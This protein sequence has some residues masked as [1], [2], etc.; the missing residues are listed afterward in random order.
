MVMSV[1]ISFF[2]CAVAGGLRGA[3]AEPMSGVENWSPWQSL[4][5]DGSL[6]SQCEGLGTAQ[7]TSLADCQQRCL[8]KPGCTTISW[9]SVQVCVLSA[10]EEC[11]LMN[12]PGCM[13]QAALVGTSWQ[14]STI[15]KDPSGCR[16]WVQVQQEQDGNCSYCTHLGSISAATNLEQR[17]QF[18][19]SQHPECD[20]F[21]MIKGWGTC[22]LK[23]CNGCNSQGDAGCKL[24][25][26]GAGC[27]VFT[28]VPR[29][30]TQIAT[31]AEGLVSTC[32]SVGSASGPW[33]VCASKCLGAD[34]CNAVSSDGQQCSLKNCS[35]SCPSQWG[36]CKLTESSTGH[37]I[38][39]LNG[40]GAKRQ[41]QLPFVYPELLLP[42]HGDLTNRPDGQPWEGIPA[43]QPPIF[44]YRPPFTPNIPGFDLHG[45][46][47]MRGRWCDNTG[48]F[49]T[50]SMSV[51][52]DGMWNTLDFSDLPGFA[53]NDDGFGNRGDGRGRSMNVVFDEK[54][55]LYTVLHGAVRISGVG[56]SSVLLRGQKVDDTWKFDFAALKKGPSAFEL[57]QS[58]D[59]LPGP[60]AVL[61]WD[62]R[63]ACRS[64][65]MGCPCTWDHTKT[66]CTTPSR[67][68]PAYPNCK[69]PK[70]SSLGA[71]ELW[72]FIETG[73]GLQAMAP[74]LLSDIAL[75]M[76][77]HSG[78]SS[79]LVTH[80]DITYA[81]YYEAASELEP[82]SPTLLATV[83]RMNPQTLPSSVEF[84]GHG[85]ST[86]HVDDPH[87]VPSLLWCGVRM[88]HTFTGTHNQ[89]VHHAV[90]EVDS[91]GQLTK[92]AQYELRGMVTYL[93]LACDSDGVI[94]AVYRDYSVR[95]ED[96]YLIGG[97]EHHKLM[98]NYWTGASGWRQSGRVLVVP[99]TKIYGVFYHKLSI[100]R[101]ANLYLL[102][103]V[104]ST[105][106]PFPNKHFAG[107]IENNSVVWT[108]PASS[109]GRQWFLFEG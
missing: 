33:P 83:P 13:L 102:H 42:S 4:A 70:G 81:V 36:D 67:C 78:G 101:E 2:V 96:A 76:G 22:Y 46:T 104:S 100:D 10:C 30:F 88:L 103:T 48:C 57:Q 98:Y 1:A 106:G 51:K 89:P 7:A 68:P 43:G 11:S 24:K 58:A 49:D 59:P 6:I 20:T 107:A 64:R 87:N 50:G 47:F 92:R 21:N 65:R 91:D 66:R 77:A 60:P 85:L 69:N 28:E 54:G 35:G 56:L 84:I 62:Q 55:T 94:H 108:S 12:I 26:H 53:K 17:C 37:G 8:W 3:I 38:F 14:V 23:K 82:G 79:M 29:C 99:G 97:A 39:I 44:N 15:G 72:R 27:D 16:T 63:L 93:A 34:G 61:T 19:C 32:A 41:L 9:D 105:K 5:S 73:E 18:A 52:M 109:L 90:F 31:A 40:L 74:V 45:R 86:T 75:P 71:L 80:A 25:P 95:G